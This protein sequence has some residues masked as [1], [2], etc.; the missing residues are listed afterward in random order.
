MMMR[1][2][3]L[4]LPVLLVGF[5]VVTSCSSTTAKRADLSDVLPV[6][7]GKVTYSGVV[8]TAGV[9]KEE[10]YRR[11]KQWLL[12]GQT[13]AVPGMDDKKGGRV[14]GEIQAEDPARGTIQG[15]K[16]LF[17]Q[18]NGTFSGSGI[19]TFAS[20]WLTITPKIK[21]AVKQGEYSYVLTEFETS[22]GIAGNRTLNLPSSSSP[23]GVWSLEPGGYSFPLEVFA[24]KAKNSTIKT[25]LLPEMD[26]D[27]KAIVDSLEKAMK[28]AAPEATQ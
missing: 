9:S 17:V 4:L 11:A 13:P 25:G 24:E 14:Y 8:Q 2:L 6:K 26:S 12:T 28:G 3:A 20:L 1:K 21:I 19:V 7:N 27:V 15:T 16:E 10:L 5:P 22:F 23:G 18:W